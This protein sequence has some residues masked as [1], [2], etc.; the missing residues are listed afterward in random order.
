MDVLDQQIVSRMRDEDE[1]E[2]WLLDLARPPIIEE[3]S[4]AGVCRAAVVEC[5][6]ALAGRG[7]FF[8]AAP[9]APTGIDAPAGWDDDTLMAEFKAAMGVF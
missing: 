1:Y 2:T 9:E 3:T 8:V 6:G 4:M 7:R 5:L